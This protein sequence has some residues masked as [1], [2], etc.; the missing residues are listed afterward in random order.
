[1]AEIIH[2]KRKRGTEG[3]REKCLESMSIAII[4]IKLLGALAPR[5]GRLRTYRDDRLREI[6]PKRNG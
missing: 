2:E 4:A 1:M 6:V 5:K 3:E